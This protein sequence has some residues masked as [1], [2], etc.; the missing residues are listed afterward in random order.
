MELTKTLVTIAGT[1]IALLAFIK[2][3][4]EF[5]HL[6]AIRRYEKFHQ[7]SVRFD[8]NDDIQDVC[9]VLHGAKPA[10]SVTKQQKEVFICFIEEIYFMM[11]SRSWMTSR[12][13]MNRDLALY[14]FGHYGQLAL[15]SERFWLGLNKKEPFYTHF[16][17]FCNLAKSY[18]PTSGADLTY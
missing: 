16:L 6:N 10:D 17:T 14:T 11:M 7:M 9:D 12:S 5:V 1:V 15:D 8:A 18:R 4:I 13:I 2:G 3:V